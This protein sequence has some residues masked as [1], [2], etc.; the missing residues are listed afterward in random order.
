MKRDYFIRSIDVKPGTAPKSQDRLVPVFFLYPP[1]RSK[2]SQCNG[3]SFFIIQHNLNGTAAFW[4]K[5]C[6]EF[7]A[8][9]AGR[10]YFS[11]PI[12][13]YNPANTILPICNHVGN[14]ISFRAHSQRTGSINTNTH[15]DIPFFGKNC[16]RN[17]SRFYKRRNLSFVLYL[18]CRYVHFIPCAIKLRKRNLFY[19]THEIFFPV[20]IS[21]NIIRKFLCKLYFKFCVFLSFFF[22]STHIIANA[23]C[24]PILLQSFIWK[25]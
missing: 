5:L 9:A 17:A 2:F 16:G 12:N 8:R 23:R 10:D 18:S 1:V 3:F 21:I 15:I 13:R 19:F 24:R 20:A 22:M 25:I 11:S 14:R 4:H 6:H 7:P